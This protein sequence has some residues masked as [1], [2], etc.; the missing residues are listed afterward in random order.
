VVVAEF[1]FAA[2]FFQSFVFHF[3]VSIRGEPR[4]NGRVQDSA[5]AARAEHCE[6]TSS[7]SSTVYDATIKEP[8]KHVKVSRTRCEINRLTK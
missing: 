7:N 6:Q 4:E 8:G 5:F 2:G 1:P 3:R